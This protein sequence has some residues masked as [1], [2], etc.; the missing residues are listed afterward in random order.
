MRLLKDRSDFQKQN[1]RQLEA[2]KTV[3]CSPA[4]QKKR[5]KTFAWSTNLRQFPLVIECRVSSAVRVVSSVVRAM[6]NDVH[7]ASRD[8]R[9]RTPSPLKTR[10]LFLTRARE[11]NI[12]SGCLI[13][14]PRGTDCDVN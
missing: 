6:L 2:K 5:A 11:E 9:A 3:P 4:A 12:K 10:T 8:V 7:A 14:T 13:G 1:R